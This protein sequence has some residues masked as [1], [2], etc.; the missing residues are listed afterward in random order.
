ML[1]RYKINIIEVDGETKQESP[2]ERTS[3]ANEPK[4]D[5]SSLEALFN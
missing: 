3:N 5:L 2:S 4:K 1:T